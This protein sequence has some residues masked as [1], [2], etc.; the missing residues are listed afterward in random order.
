MIKRMAC[1]VVF[2]CYA[3]VS[4][5]GAED[6]VARVLGCS[7]DPCIVRNNDGGLVDLFEQAATAINSGA[8]AH[9]VIDGPCASACTILIDK[10]ADKVCLTKWAQLHFHKGT[11]YS[12][13]ITLYAPPT[14]GFGI[15]AK[16]VRHESFYVPTLFDPDYSPAVMRWIRAIGGLPKD[17]SFVVMPDQLARRIW[18]SCT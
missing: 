12:I 2:L 17:G 1:G 18:R 3:V 8:R 7:N 11:E 6:I 13:T 5:Y 9:I 16:E 15:S 10:V 4:A 14:F